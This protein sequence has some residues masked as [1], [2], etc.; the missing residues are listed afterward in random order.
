[1]EMQIQNS[2]EYINIGGLI[3]STY[4]NMNKYELIILL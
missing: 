2:E 4:K 1:M 3:F